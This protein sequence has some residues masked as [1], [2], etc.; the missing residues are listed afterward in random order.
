[1]NGYEL[2]IVQDNDIGMISRIHTVS[3]DDAWSGTMIRRILAMPGTFGIV[4][5]QSRRCSIAGFALGRIAADECEILSI[6]VAPDHRGAHVGSMLLDGAMHQAAQ[7]GAATLFL[8]VAED[9]DV[10][11]TL[12]DSR[13]FVPVGRRP[14]YYTRNDGSTAAAVTMS[15]G[16]ESVAMQKQA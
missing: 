14:D 9:N 3:F 15:C 2:A 8:E 11:R 5:R 6:A 16:L 1:V 13:G 10:A 12:Y 4:A 7:G